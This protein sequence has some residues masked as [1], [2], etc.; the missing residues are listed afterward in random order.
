[1]KTMWSNF[2]LQALRCCAGVVGAL[3]LVGASAQPLAFGTDPDLLAKIALGEDRGSADVGVWK[4]GRAVY[5]FRHNGPQGSSRES[6]GAEPVV[7]ASSGQQLYEIGSI[8]KVFTGLLLAQAV[9]RGDLALDDKLGM[10]L[11]DKVRFVSSDVQAI[12]LRQLITHSACMPRVP[13]D[14]SEERVADNPYATY[15][16]RRLWLALSGLRLEGPPPCAA[17]YSNFGLGVVGEILSER[18]GKPW[19]VLVRENITA[20]LGMHDTVQVLGD[21]SARMAPAFNNATATPLWD[22]DALAGAGALRSTAADLLVF[23]R[24]VMAGKNGPLGHAAERMLTPLGRY[25]SSQIAY[26]VMMRGP[27]GR[28]I[29]FHDGATGGYRT[30]WMVAPDTQEALVALTSNAHG[31]P[32]KVFVGIT[33]GRYPVTGA[34]VAVDAGVL[35]AYAGVFRVDQ[36]TAFTFVLQDGMLYRRITGGGFRPLVATG[37]DTFADPAIGVQYVFTRQ[38]GAVAGVD[39]TQG[40][41]GMSGI[42]TGEPAPVVA[43]VPIDRQDD[44]AGRFQL[45]RTLRRKLDF[46]VKVEGGQLAV[47]SSNWPR[48]PVFPMA[49][50]PDRFAYEN[51]K[52]ELLF[53]RDAAGKVVALVLFEGGVMRMPRAPE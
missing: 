11:R 8:S 46:D 24:A 43:V 12:T 26:A 13:P 14:F 2:R 5:A 17:S 38:G 47:R 36:R 39:Y 27:E 28:R 40:G 41:G 33:A 22:F 16:R 29:Y 35:A 19:Q 6:G 45:E 37:P 9:E 10:L 53:E 31:Q 18:Y 34:P 20:P 50:Q 49:G 30:L 32:G 21:K 42:R 23:S 3:W 1:M 52:A 44:Y 4:D 25:Q 51:G 7:Q 48:L 15:D